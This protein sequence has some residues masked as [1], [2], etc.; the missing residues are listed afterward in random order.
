MKREYRVVVE[1]Y[2]V[3]ATLGNDYIAGRESFLLLD[4]EE[5]YA[6]PDVVIANA[7]KA[8][9]MDMLDIETP[10]REGGR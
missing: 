7:A 8:M 9:V 2:V 6:R 4:D 5:P 3:P 10:A 1:A